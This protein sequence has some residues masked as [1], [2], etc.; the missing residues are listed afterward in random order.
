M[1]HIHYILQG[2][3]GVGKSLIAALMMQYQEDNGM[4]AIA[5]DTDPV[6]ASFTAYN[7]WNYWTSINLCNRD[8]SMI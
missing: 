1:P 5:V 4:P 8:A 2:K 6:N 3:G 7:A